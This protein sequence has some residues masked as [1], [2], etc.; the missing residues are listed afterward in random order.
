M[1]ADPSTPQRSDA[2]D[3]IF[4]QGCPPA[5]SRSRA[6][7]PYSRSVDLAWMQK[8]LNE[9]YRLIERGPEEISEFVDDPARVRHRS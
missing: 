8:T 5:A 3:P 1:G 4:S 6:G 2:S 9:Y 7:E